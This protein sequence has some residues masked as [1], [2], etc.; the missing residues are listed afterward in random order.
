MTRD[1]ALPEAAREI[2]EKNLAQTRE[3]YERSKGA[4]EAGVDTLARS[5][6]SR[7]AQRR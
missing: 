2:A 4:L 6:D 7:G 5:F 1:P 3:T